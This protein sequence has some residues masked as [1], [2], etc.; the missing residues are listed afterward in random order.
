[1]LIITPYFLI[2]KNYGNYFFYQGFFFIYRDPLYTIIG[3]N[4]QKEQVIGTRSLADVL[5]NSLWKG[6]NNQMCPVSE[7]D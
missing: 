2:K 6:P 4:N 3:L 5:P 1:M 7:F